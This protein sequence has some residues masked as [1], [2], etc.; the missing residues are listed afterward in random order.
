MLQSGQ[1][2]KCNFQEE[3]HTLTK[4]LSLNDSA[5]A[6]RSS[7]EVKWDKINLKVP[8]S[9]PIPSKLKKRYYL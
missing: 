2:F 3:W 8:G 4:F 1:N 9:L 5:K 7:S 6:S